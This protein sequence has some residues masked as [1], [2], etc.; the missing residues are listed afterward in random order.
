MEKIGFRGPMP[1]G[2]LFAVYDS[3][4]GYPDYIPPEYIDIQNLSSLILGQSYSAEK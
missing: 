1:P 4:T 3:K 2:V